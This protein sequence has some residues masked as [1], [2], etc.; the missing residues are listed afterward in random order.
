MIGGS[1]DM[2]VSE[3]S[4]MTNDYTEIQTKKVNFTG[5]A[6]IAGRFDLG[7]KR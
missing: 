3:D 4:P 1:L 7:G 2:F 5:F 6:G